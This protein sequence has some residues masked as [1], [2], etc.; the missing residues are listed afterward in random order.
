M[1]EQVLAVEV[2]PPSG[3]PAVEQRDQAPALHRVRDIDPGQLDD[4]GRYV[5]VEGHLI[6]AGAPPGILEARVHHHQG[7]PDGVLVQQPAVAQAPLTEEHAV[8][9]GEDHH[10]GFGRAEIV[11]LG[12]HPAQHHVDAADHPVVALHVLLEQLGSAEPPQPALPVLTVPD[13]V[14][15]RLDEGGVGRGGN[16]NDGVV[17]EVVDAGGPD[18]LLGMVVL[19]VGGV[20]A[21]RQAERL[22]GVRAVPLPE[23]ADHL[24]AGHVGEVP[25]AAVGLALE[26]VVGPPVL[27]VVE[28]VEHR[29]EDG[30]L[31][32]DVH[33]TVALYAELADETG[34]VAGRL[35][36]G[37][38]GDRAERGPERR[39]AEVELVAAPVHA[40]QE[41]GPARAANRRGYE[42]VV[43]H[44]P[45][46]SQVVHVRGPDD[47]VAGR[48]HR[49]PVLI[50]GQQEQDVRVIGL[51]CGLRSG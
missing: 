22:L 39:G 33:V 13:E 5:D 36:Q 50:V 29:V 8:V 45:P 17:V 10:S 49:G 26:V 41:A 18:V 11:Q 37:R 4:G 1:L 15:L 32:L 48:P 51:H 38:V 28:V 23:E 6:G 12:Q 20:E 3:E 2:L 46:G 14:G 25:Q 44:H 34:P 19:A 21:D 40:G 42:G 43:E 16:R 24:V 31:V 35:Q 27:E 30:L 47:V 9:A 7:H